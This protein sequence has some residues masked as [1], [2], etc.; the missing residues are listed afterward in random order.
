MVGRGL[1][2]TERLPTD[3]G[4]EFKPRDCDRNIECT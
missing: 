2:V 3:D 4:S 1:S